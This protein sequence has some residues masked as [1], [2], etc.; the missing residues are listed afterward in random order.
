M[1]SDSKIVEQDGLSLGSTLS[2]F[3]MTSPSSLVYFLGISG[4]Y[5]L[6][7]FLYRPFISYALK[8]GFRVVIS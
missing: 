5:P 6:S 1:M 4:Y 3:I 8:G 2:S 7:T